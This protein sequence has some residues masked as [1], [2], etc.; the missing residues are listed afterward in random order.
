MEIRERPFVP[1]EV[2]PLTLAPSGSLARAYLLFLTGAAS[3]RAALASGGVSSPFL[4]LPGPSRLGV[5]ALAAA[6][7]AC[8]SSRPA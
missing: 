3:S 4:G 1:V 5:A 6:L 7:A 8:H 2:F